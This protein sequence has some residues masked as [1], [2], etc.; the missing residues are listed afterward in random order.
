MDR[1]FWLQRWQ[2]N[3]IGFHG[4]EVHPLLVAHFNK[5]DV[6]E[7]SR[8]FL[9]LCG[10]TLDIS[11]L[12]SQG[13]PVVGVE[14]SETAIEQLFVELGVSPEVS[15]VGPLKLYRGNDIDIFAGDIFELTADVLGSVEAI[16]D[17]AALVAL[18]GD[19]RAR[20]A[21]HLTQ[22]TGRAP[23]LLICFEYDQ[24]AMPGPPFSI[25]DEE[26]HRHYRDSYDLRSVAR[27]EVLGGLK[28][29]CEARENV[30]LLRPE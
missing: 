13:Y 28:G 12:L 19:V 7:G 18:P 24:N 9:P 11:W 17:R 15:A 20:Y 22:I 10:K 4:R 5:L 16:Y 21:A 8:V 1:S 3:D 25:G 30:W 2:S 29:R 14:L 26:V 27:T 6:A 23:Q